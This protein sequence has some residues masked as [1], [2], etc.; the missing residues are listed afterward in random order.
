M[1]K[2]NLGMRLRECRENEEL[3]Q[4]ACGQI[5]GIPASTWSN[6]EN[7]YR[8]PDYVVLKNFAERFNVSLD[9]LLGINDFKGH[10]LAEE[11][12]DFIS[13]YSEADEDTQIQIKKILKMEGCK[14]V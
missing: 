4:K 11:E 2:M 12:Y 10:I 3:T 7:F 6:Y 13:R 1:N 14:N 9:Y 8:V 5:F